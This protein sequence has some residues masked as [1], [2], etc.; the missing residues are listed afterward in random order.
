M[1]VKI[2]LSQA[3]MHILQPNW[4]ITFSSN[5]SLPTY[6]NHISAEIMLH[7]KQPPKSQGFL[8]DIYFTLTSMHVCQ[9]LC[10]LNWAHLG[11]VGFR[12]GHFQICFHVSLCSVPGWKSS[13]YLR[14]APLKTKGRSSRRAG[15]N[16]I[17]LPLWPVL[18]IMMSLPL[19]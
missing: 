5:L 18:T 13:S 11:Q 6:H 10:D 16:F 12:P 15:R 2:L 1:Q 19:A 7:N 17:I 9:R 3:C 14:H 8:T 4:T